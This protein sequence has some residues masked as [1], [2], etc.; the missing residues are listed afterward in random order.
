MES[1]QRDLF[2]I[3]SIKTVILNEV[4]V[5]RLVGVPLG[6]NLYW[7]SPACSR[8]ADRSEILLRFVH[9]NDTYNHFLRNHR[10]KFEMIKIPQL[11]HQ[12][13]LYQNLQSETFAL[14][15]NFS[16]RPKPFS[17]THQFPSHE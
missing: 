16:T 9:Q 4:R 6:K 1:S 14:Q 15:E 12:C 2:E 17:A 10:L 7:F 11:L 13:L 8:R 5:P 3:K